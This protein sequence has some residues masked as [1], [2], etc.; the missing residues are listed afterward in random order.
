MKG[1][2]CLL[3][4]ALYAAGLCRFFHNIVLEY[5]A[6]VT[7]VSTHMKYLIVVW[8]WAHFVVPWMGLL[9]LMNS[10]GILWLTRSEE[11]TCFAFVY[12]LQFFCD[13][14]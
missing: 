12:W 2:A 9:A 1:L 6:P 13:T 14:N 3:Y 8:V 10:A 7:R 5:H 11:F 4:E